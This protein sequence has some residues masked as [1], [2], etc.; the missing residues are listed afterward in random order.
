MPR[1]LKFLH[2]FLLG[3]AQRIFGAQALTALVLLGFGASVWTTLRDDICEQE[4]YIV[5]EKDFRVWNPPVWTSDRFVAEALELR[6]P[7]A[8]NEPLNSLDPNLIDHLLVAFESHPWVERVESIETRFPARVDV[9]IRFKEPVAVVDPTPAIAVD[10]SDSATPVFHGGESERGAE[11]AES[12]G[13]VFEKYVVDAKGYRLPDEYFRAN[14]SAYRRFPIILG[15]RS[16]PVSGAG[17]CGD[18]LV[19]EAAAFA[20]FLT[21][22]DAIEK[23]GV[24][25]IIVAKK[26]GETTPVYCLKTEGNAT[27]YWG[28]FA[29]TK[30][31]EPADQ[32]AVR[33]RKTR[34][35]FAVAEKYGTLEDV[36]PEAA[37]ELDLSVEEN[38]AG[39]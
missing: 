19:V 16:T 9:K 6:A 11:I 10:W 26:R 24:N 7:E 31:G 34:R 21:V 30:D 25:R 37:A 23:L 27:V 20:R 14:P 8:R 12:S 18:P 35:L 36:P 2:Y 38:V 13:P 15:I 3:R 22:A 28:T 1:L 39:K 5:K 29:A 4:V 33:Q 17:Q 32:D